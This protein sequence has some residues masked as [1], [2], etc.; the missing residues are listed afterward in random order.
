MIHGG[1]QINLKID[2]NKIHYNHCCLRSDLFEYDSGDMWNSEQLIPLRELNKENKWDPG[3][4][5]CR[6]NE[7]SSQTSLR[8]GTLEMFGQSSNL[9]G[10]KRLDL[11]FDISCNLACRTC[12][13]WAS[14]YWQKHL[15]EN[16]IEF[17]APSPETRVDEMIEILRTLDLSNLELVV[18]CGGET[19]MGQGYWRV[20]EVIA[21]LAP[22]AKEKITLS[23]QTNGTQPINQKNY[24]T[25]KKFHLVKLNFSLDGINERFEYLRWPAK[26]QQVVGNMFTI[27]DT[28]P[29]NTMFLVE[30]T[31]SIFNLYYQNELESWLKQNFPTNRLGDITNHTRHLTTEYKTRINYGIKELTREYVESLPDDLRGLVPNNWQENPEA[32]RRMIADI[33]KFDKFRNQDW[34]KTFPEVAAFYHRFKNQ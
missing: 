15:K 21:E 17:L 32:I 18:F 14:T 12:G 5:A 3:C 19:L 31:M 16:A 1:L 9:S 13:P 11:M 4:W 34:T 30:E 33:E 29:V 26:W 20:A 24:E 23:F 7:L 22:Q 6:G 2:K 8:T 28:A 10:P 27:R 25:L